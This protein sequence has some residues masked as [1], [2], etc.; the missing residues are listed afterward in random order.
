MNINERT[1]SDYMMVIAPPAEVDLMIAKYKKATARVIGDFEG[2]YSPTHI[3]VTAQHRQMPDM[4][5]QKLDIY[6]KYINRLR[7]VTLHINGFSF[8]KHGD[9]GAT[10]YAKIAIDAELNIWFTHLKRTFGDKSKNTLPHIT[11]AKNI[12]IEKFRRLWPKFIDQQYQYSFIPQGITVLRRPMIGG[13][14]LY[15]TVFKELYF[16]N[17]G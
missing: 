1:Y 9:M 3:S 14:D 10:I 17:F 7:P 13:K 4:M 15:W 5:K 12:P 6:L 8:F 11:V 16:N 2:M